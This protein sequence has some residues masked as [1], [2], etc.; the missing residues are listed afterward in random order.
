MDLKC[1]FS[2]AILVSQISLSSTQNVNVVIQGA[3]SIGE[4]DDNFDL[5]KK[6]LINAIKA[7]NPLRIKVGGSLQDQVVYGVGG[8]KN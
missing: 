5:K 2:L 7:F 1:I 4:T 6:G 8:V 3:T